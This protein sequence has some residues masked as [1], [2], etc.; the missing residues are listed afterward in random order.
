MSTEFEDDPVGFLDALLT[1]RKEKRESGPAFPGS[2]PPRNIV[3]ADVDRS[4]LEWL[5][6]IPAQEFLVNGQLRKF[7]TIGALANAIGKKAGTIRSWESKGWIPHASFRTPPPVA[8][9]LPDKAIKGRRLYSWEQLKFLVEHHE[10]FI[11]DGKND[12][13]GF[14]A[15]ITH[16]YPHT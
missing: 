9:Q 15:A 12:W 2:R 14:R 6:D 13:V 10:K 16:H 11:S 4:S 3:P 7:Y 1:E 5:N 8:S